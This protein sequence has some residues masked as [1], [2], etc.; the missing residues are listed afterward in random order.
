MRFEDEFTGRHVLS[1]F[2]WPWRSKSPLTTQLL[3][4]RLTD[5]ELSVY[6]KLP[7]PD[8]DSP[9]GLLNGEELNTEPIVDLDLFF[10]SLYNYYCEKGLRLNVTDRDI[11]TTSW[12]V[13]LEKV[14][15]LQRSQQLCVIRNLTAHDIVM[16]M[17]RKE[18]YLIGMLNK[19]VLAFPIHC[20][21]PGAGPV[22]I[23]NGR[24]Y[25]MILPKTLEWTLNWC[26]FQSMFDS[27]FQLVAGMICA[28]GVARHGMVFGRN[29]FWYA[30]IFGSVTAISRAAIADELQVLDHEGAMSLVVDHTHYM[31]KKWHGK[32]N[33][34]LVRSE[35]E[36]LFQ[37][38]DDIVRFVSDYT[39]YVDGVG[40][41]CSFSAF[42]FKSHGNG[43]YGSPHDAARE[44]R[45]SQGKMEKSFFSFQCTYPTWEP[46]DDGRRFLSTLQNF[47]EKQIHQGRLQD[48]SH[49]WTWQAIRGLRVRHEIIHRFPSG[50]VFS[51][52]GGFPRYDHHPGSVWLTNHEQRNHP[53]ILDWYYTSKPL[54]DP[55][56]P[57]DS[58]S[59]EK[60]MAFESIQ[61]FHATQSNLQTEVKSTDQSWD[62]PFSDRLQSHIEASTSGSLLKNSAPQDL[63]RHIMHHRWW[64]RT[65]LTSSAA[66][67]S[68]LEPPSFGH[69]DY[70]HH[71]DDVHG[72]GSEY[73][74]NLQRLSEGSDVGE[75][76]DDEVLDL[77]FVDSYDGSLKNLTVRIPRTS[78]DRIH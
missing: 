65:A 14:I 59:S 38:V 8:P 12:P 4:D 51:G 30:A 28:G 9:S 29:L 45:S 70:S 26:I 62:L 52:N 40:H 41:I 74:G 5:V 18:N 75:A 7:G 67:A 43:Q 34:D 37:R 58:P 71:S 77:P 6:S 68:F 76:D 23:K 57:Q 35:F 66:Q 16:R 63:D 24:K 33:S 13:M 39:V 2:E 46:S 11:Q 1:R 17:M 55:A 64:D 25:H 36:T 21:I 15:K 10:G 53:Y 60:E 19:R 78:D 31:P 49:T 20:W 54:E 56:N 32:E 48:N 72:G 73:L 42:D 27:T 50:N 69:H 3:D 61:D 22:L 47:K 44:R